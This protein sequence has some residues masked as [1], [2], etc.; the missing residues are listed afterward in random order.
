MPVAPGYRVKFP[1]VAWELISTH[2]FLMGKLWS[3][4]IESVN[5]FILPEFQYF[6][7]RKYYNF[8]EIILEMYLK[9]YL[10]KRLY[11]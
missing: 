4:L 6:I 10:K 5:K 7:T 9:F 3:K 2:L 8:I 11:L 1:A